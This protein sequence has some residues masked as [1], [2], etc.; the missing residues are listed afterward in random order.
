MGEPTRKRALGDTAEQAAV[1]HLVAQG[2]QIEARNFSCKYGEL[3][4]VA[5]RDHVLCFVE[6]RMRSTALWGDPSGTITFSKQRRVVKTA[7]HYLVAHRIR[8]LALR[9]DVIAVVGRG[10]GAIVEHLENA[11]DAGM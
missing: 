11:F 4:I 3:D 2:Y 9:F 1:D 6:V 7:L 10:D 8:D 5:R